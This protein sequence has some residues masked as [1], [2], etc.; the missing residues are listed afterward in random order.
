MMT[1]SRNRTRG[2][3]SKVIDTRI[4][5]PSPPP[6]L[7]ETAFVST[8]FCPDALFCLVA[9]SDPHELYSRVKEIR[10]RYAQLA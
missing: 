4:S 9:L 3:H 8:Q 2:L 6:P 1:R 10:K 5:T 7:P